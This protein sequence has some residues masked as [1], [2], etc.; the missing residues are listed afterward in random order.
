[1]IGFSLQDTLGNI[2]GG[3]ALQMERTIRVG[4]W[5]YIDAPKPELYDLTADPNE[6]KN[7]YDD[8]RY[9][10]NADALDVE[11]EK[12]MQDS[13]KR[14]QLVSGEAFGH[15]RALH[16]PLGRRLHADRPGY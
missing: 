2:M 3:M 9:R 1:M 4:D 6:T 7:L 12:L 13:A 10:A 11:L 8:P 5:K 16:A 14:A 15:F